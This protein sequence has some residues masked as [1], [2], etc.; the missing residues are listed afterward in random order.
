MKLKRE[1]FIRIEGILNRY[2]YSYKTD[3]VEITLEFCLN[4]FD[5]A[6]YD[7]N[8]NLLEP[9]VCTDFSLEDFKTLP[10]EKIIDK[11]IKIAN[12]FYKKYK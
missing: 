10:R 12:T 4:G 8:E 6:V 2:Y 3:K 11:A 7:L 5:V 1:D 9:K